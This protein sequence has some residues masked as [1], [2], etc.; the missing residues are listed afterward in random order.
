MQFTDDI[1]VIESEDAN[2][3]RTRQMKENALRDLKNSTVHRLQKIATLASELPWWTPGLA[4]ALIQCHLANNGDVASADA[5]VT[6][7]LSSGDISTHNA[8]MLHEPY[9]RHYARVGDLAAAVDT[10]KDM[11]ARN[12]QASHDMLVDLFDACARAADMSAALEVLGVV[13]GAG[14]AVTEPMLQRLVTTCCATGEHAAA[15][16]LAKMAGECDPLG[17]HAWNNLLAEV[18]VHL[19]EACAV[20]MLDTLKMH[21]IAHGTA[22][23]QLVAAV[24]ELKVKEE[25]ARIRRTELQTAAPPKRMNLKEYWDEAFEELRIAIHTTL[26]QNAGMMEI[27]DAL[28][29][30][31]CGCMVSPVS[32]RA[33]CDVHRRVTALHVNRGS[34]V[35]FV[36]RHCD[37]VD[38]C[39]GC[40]CVYLRHVGR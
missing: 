15:V 35:D 36:E 3:Q 39:A 23:E 13:R 31:G 1:A 2:N 20:E 7:A 11:L 26:G 12:P 30:V 34:V 17:S 18:H 5:V 9:V 19:G 8:A 28:D 37:R 40:A 27:T 6:Q 33:C 22:P 29:T 10:L 4:S 25:A 16:A 38:V 21:G 14:I 32:L 24:E